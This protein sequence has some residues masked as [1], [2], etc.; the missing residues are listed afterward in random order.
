MPTW[1]AP[2]AP[3]PPEQVIGGGMLAITFAAKLKKKAAAARAKNGLDLETG[4]RKERW[5][6]LSVSATK[7]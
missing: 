2:V 5:A 7:R 4:Q 3:S 6:L 1:L